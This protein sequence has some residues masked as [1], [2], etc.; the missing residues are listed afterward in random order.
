VAALRGV[1][2]QLGTWEPPVVPALQPPVST[3]QPWWRTIPAWAQVAAALLFVG[4][5]ATIANLDVRYDRN[6]FSLNTGWSTR[7][8]A[9]SLPVRSDESGRS[10]GAPWRSDL[11]A[12][13]QQLEMEFRA[14]QASA[15][16][17]AAPAQTTRAASPDTETL[18]RVRVL[19]DESEKRQQREL[20]LRVAEVL[21]D[22]NAQRQADL[23]KIDRSLGVVSTNAG[24]D[25]MKSRRELMD[26]IQR[27]SL[28]Q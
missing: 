12:L 24:V 14:S 27:V 28:R 23:V 5:S 10:G 11:T 9:S 16:S 19:L 8:S 4:V 21:R 3:P 20:A 6:G 13:Q 18:R 17:V 26:Y 1:R 22:V 7:P 15:G 2:A 25:V